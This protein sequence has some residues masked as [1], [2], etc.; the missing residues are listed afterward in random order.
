MIEL[1]ENNGCWVNKYMMMKRETKDLNVQTAIDTLYREY[2]NYTI[3]NRAIPCY[4]DGLKPVQRKVLYNMLT[5]YGYGKKVKVV[6]GG[7][8]SSIGYKHG[9]TSAQSATILMTAEYNNNYPLFIGHGAFGT[10]QVP[11]PSAPR[12]IY[13]ELSKNTYN[14]FADND[15]LV[16][17]EQDKTNLDPLYYLPVIP[18]LL[19]NGS[20]GIAVGFSTNILPYSVIDIKKIMEYYYKSNIHQAYKLI[21]D[22]LPTFPNFNGEVYRDE[23]NP[24][25]YHITG[26]VDKIP[27]KRNNSKL[28]EYVI[29]ELPYSYSRESY[30][31]ILQKLIDTNKIVDF[32]DE[33]TDTFRFKIVVNSYDCDKIDKEPLTYFKIKTSMVENLTVIDENGKLR[34]YTN[35]KEL[36][37]DW[38]EFRLKQSKKQIEIDISKLNKTISELKLKLEFINSIINGDI[39]IKTSS[40]EELL[41]FIDGLNPNIDI[42]V[43]KSIISSPIHS[44][45]KDEVK[46][47]QKKI[48][49]V[50][51]NI[52]EFKNTNEFTRLYNLLENVNI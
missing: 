29:T 51:N 35:K 23:E 22:L 1:Q 41:S 34:E 39:D 26:I 17:D 30:Y 10:R 46:K 4:V 9:E 13:I 18:L 11:E 36:L 42:S 14:I 47:L 33:C 31:E 52:D 48:D 2:A 50:Q 37:D 16:Y 5:N 20:K 49:D 38:V 19:L 7:S 25:K 32:V 6:D 21:D 8:I 40:Y 44:L 28:T 43:K 12:Y 27:T 15:T 3:S 45:T 24:N